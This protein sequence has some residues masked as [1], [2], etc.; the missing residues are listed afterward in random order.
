MSNIY[1]K[2]ENQFKGQKHLG[3]YKLI[4]GLMKKR[5]IDNGQDDR[6]KKY[7][8]M[9]QNKCQLQIACGI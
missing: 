6:E 2:N 4:S 1:E 5:K 9:I 8:K 7:K 3:N